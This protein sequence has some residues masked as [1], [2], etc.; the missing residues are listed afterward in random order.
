LIEAIAEYRKM[1][2]LLTINIKLPYIC[3]I[4]RKF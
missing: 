2:F 1:D 3:E 4:H